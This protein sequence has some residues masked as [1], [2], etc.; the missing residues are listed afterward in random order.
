MSGRTF[1]ENHGLGGAAPLLGRRAVL[2]VS[3][4]GAALLMTRG[5]AM[6]QAVPPGGELAFQLVRN[7]DVIGH[8]T[9]G[10]TTSG[11]TL[12]VRVAV[13]IKVRM[14]MITVY[15]LTHEETE[16][17]QDGQILSFAASTVKNGTRLYSQGW[18]NGT[19]FM[20]RGTKHPDAYVTPP[21]AL[22]TSQ[23]NHAMLNGPM[24]NTEDGR[25][26]HPTVTD[27]GWFNLPMANGSMVRTRHYNAAGDLH[28]DTYFSESWEW[29]GLSFKADDG[30]LVSY[31]RL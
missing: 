31:Q 6:A 28:F 26:M 15:S 12:T 7:S 9:I 17:W 4:G 10:F 30:S 29:M 2:G 19:Q 16:T 20:A 13:K 18:R 3:A 23:W 14:A 5:R 1:L 27:K 22:P 21:N 11:Q 25:L 8:Q 24:I